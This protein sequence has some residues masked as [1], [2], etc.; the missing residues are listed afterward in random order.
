MQSQKILIS[1][2]RKTLKTF[3]PIHGNE[4]IFQQK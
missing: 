1:G 2:Y 4:K 3:T